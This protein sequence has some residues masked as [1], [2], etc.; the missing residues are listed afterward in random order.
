MIEAVIFDFDGV[1]ADTM[2]DNCTAWQKAFEPYGFQLEAHEYYQLEGMG[3]FQIAELIVAR[4]N[5]DKSIVSDLVEFKEQY[6]KHNNT[7]RIYDGIEDIFRILAD[8]NIPAAI[9]TGASRARIGTHL[10]SQLSSQLSALITADDVTHTKPHPE[11][12]LKA[13][14]LLG[15]VAGNCL[16]IENAV[17]GIQSAKAAG[18][19]CFALQTTLEKEDLAMA[20]EIFATHKDLLTKFEQLFST[21]K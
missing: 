13:V 18:C 15:K 9:V 8:S 7:F 5:L 6:Y 19:R 10:S 17:L 4:H 16:V 14:A 1:V 20:D 3:R 21:H 12:Y 2:K 11:P